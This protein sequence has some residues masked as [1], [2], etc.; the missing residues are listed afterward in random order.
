MRLLNK[1]FYNAIHY[2]PR[3]ISNRYDSFDRIKAAPQNT[4]AIPVKKRESELVH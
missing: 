1:A 3:M 2:N 4:A